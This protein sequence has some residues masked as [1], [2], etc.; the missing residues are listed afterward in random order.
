MRAGGRIPRE[1]VARAARA[2]ARQGLRIARAAS[3]TAAASA[4]D[5]A[6]RHDEAGAE[7]ANGLGD[8][9]DVVRDGGDAGAERA[10]QRAALVELR[11]GTGRPRPSPRRARD[12]P[13]TPGGSRAATRRR[14]LRRVRYGST[15]SSG[16]PAT[17]RRAPPARRTAS[18][19]SPS[20]L[21]ARMTPNAS[22]V[23]PSSR[24]SRVAREDGVGDD[25]A[26]RRRD[27]ASVSRPCSLWTTT[28]SK[29]ASRRRQSSSFARRAPRQQ[30]VRGE[31]RRAHAAGRGARRAPG[32][33]HCRCSTS[34]GGAAQRGEP[35][36]MLGDLQRQPQPRAAEEPR[37]DGIE[38]LAADVAVRGAG[39]SPKRKRDVTSSTSAPARARAAAS[40]WSY[41][42][43]KAGGS[44]RTIAHGP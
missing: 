19:A 8:A 43:V 16:S 42:G 5:V 17:S 7:A 37:R 24:R 13:R 4:V 41:A 34:A 2:G 30:V 10:Q 28:R 6:G 21:Y 11:A 14:R 20:P 15:G 3:A 31:D 1:L 26:R 9:A 23:R 40:S 29:R 22:T 36:R 35:E 25:A 39:A 12:R 32:T 44:A 33:S 18:I 27:A 38:E